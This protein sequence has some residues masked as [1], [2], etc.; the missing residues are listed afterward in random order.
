MSL[1]PADLVVTMVPLATVSVLK[2]DHINTLPCSD[3]PYLVPSLH[4]CRSP[5]G[6]AVAGSRRGGRV[7]ASARASRWHGVLRG[8][9][10]AC[11]RRDPVPCS[12][13]CYRRSC[14]VG[15]GMGGWCVSVV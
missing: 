12:R 10:G 2:Q 9:T 15:W 11:D 3:W 14:G 4:G 8:V 13:P 1:R 5:G 6:A 7:A